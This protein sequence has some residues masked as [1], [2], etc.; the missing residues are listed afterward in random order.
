MSGS[1]NYTSSAP[2][3]GFDQAW[4]D[5]Q[6]KNGSGVDL[7][8]A[9]I[10]SQQT[11]GKWT[12]QGHGSVLENAKSMARRLSDAGIKR[13]EDFGQRQTTVN[14]EEGPQQTV[15]YFN[16]RN[17]QKVLGDQQRDGVLDVT[18]A[19]DGSTRFGVSFNEMGMPVFYSQY[20]GSSSDWGSIAPFLSVASFIP[21]VAPFAM[22]FSALGN[23]YNGNY[24]GA[25]LSA[26]G[27][28]QSYGAEYLA[29]AENLAERKASAVWIWQVILRLALL[30]RGLA[31]M[32]QTSAPPRKLLAS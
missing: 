1:D 24:V 22:A 25:A 23:A 30:L 7:L 8:T 26:L 2:P 21:G 20:N 18:Y 5:S 6:L 32:Q 12:G 16:K 31:R 29:G 9:Q 15:E 4:I 11:Y 27:A 28:A 13:L 19:G 10:L 17:G 14:T 3:L